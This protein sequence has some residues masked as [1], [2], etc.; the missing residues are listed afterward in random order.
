LVRIGTS[1]DAG[2]ADKFFQLFDIYGLLIVNVPQ[3]IC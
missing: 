2:D 1:A 3:C